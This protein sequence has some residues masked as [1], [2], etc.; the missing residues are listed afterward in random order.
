MRTVVVGQA[1]SRTSDPAEPLSGRSGQRLA[2]LCGVTMPEFLERFERINLLV[3]WQGKSGK[4][5]RF[6]PAEAP[7][8]VAKT[9]EYLRGRNVVV[10]GAINATSLGVLWPKL[11]F[12]PFNAG[13]FAWCP[14]P[15]GI[16]VWWNDRVNVAEAR[17]FWTVTAQGLLPGPSPRLPAS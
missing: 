2:E 4:G 7:E 13:N 6:D 16:N 10:L 8:R 5:D 3:G 11:S 15:S 12:R 1:S 14:H 9:M 17:R